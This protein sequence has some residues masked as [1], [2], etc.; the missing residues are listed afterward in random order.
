MGGL[1]LV[2]GTVGT[3]CAC[4][5]WSFPLLSLD[6]LALSQGGTRWRPIMRP[7]HRDSTT[8]HFCYN[9]PCLEMASHLLHNEY[10]KNKLFCKPKKMRFANNMSHAYYI[11]VVVIA[12]DVGTY[13][14]QRLM[15]IHQ[16]GNFLYMV[17]MVRH[18]VVS[19]P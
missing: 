3:P 7:L 13:I 17:P 14:G 9:G 6:G 1:T 15:I 12:H 16:V 5:F 18:Y 2:L 8:S 4:V 10:M 11:V 19:Y